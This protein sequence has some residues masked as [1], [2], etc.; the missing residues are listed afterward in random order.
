MPSPDPEFINFQTR[1]NRRLKEQADHVAKYHGFA[2]LQHVVRLFIQK[3]AAGELE[4][5]FFDNESR[6]SIFTDKLKKFA[7]QNMKNQ[8]YFE[9]FIGETYENP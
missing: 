1:I 2:S 6:K 3:I 5:D 7:R 8:E 4:V 9:E